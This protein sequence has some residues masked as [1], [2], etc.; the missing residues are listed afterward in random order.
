[1]RRMLPW[2][3]VPVLLAGGLWL[4]RPPT[5]GGDAA[6]PSFAVEGK[7]F[8]A[9]HCTSC[10]GGSAPEAGLSLEGLTLAPPTLRDATQLLDLRKRVVAR[11]MPPLG[12]PAPAPAELAAFLAA[13]DAALVAADAAL[14]PDPG[15]VTV[16]RLSR[17]EYGRTVKHLL[18][19]DYEPGASFPADDLSYGFDNIGASLSMSPL[20]LEKYADAAAEIAARAVWLE[21]PAHPPVRRLEAEGLEIEP[22]RAGAVRGEGAGLHGN[23][24]VSGTVRLPREG[25]YLLRARVFGQQAGPDP[26]RMAF[27]VDGR[28]V[29]TVDVP[30][31]SASIAVKEWR[32]ALGAGVR[33]VGVAFVN[34]Y[35]RP[36]EPDPAQRDRNLVVDWIEVV[37]PVDARP[38][39]AAH[40]RLFA[41]DP[42]A[43][44]RDPGK[45]SVKARAEPI[46][47][48][49]AS[50]AWRR[51]ATG[52]EVKRLVTL[53]EA[54]VERGVRLEEGVGLALQAVL[55][56]P[57]FLFRLE[58]GAATGAGGT[59]RDLDGHALATRLSY[60][61]WS[62]LPD[63]ALAVL[64]ARG[65]LA[66]LATL[67]AEVR[68]MLA[69][70]R[71]RALSENFAVQWLELRRL[72]TFVPDPERYPGFEALREPMRQEAEHL[73]EAV[74]RERRDVH[75][76]LDAR[77]TFVDAALAGHY[78]LPV[79]AGEGL[80][81]VDL[82]GGQRGGVLGLAGVLAVTSNPTRTSPV[83][84]GK[85]VL[86]NVL[87]APPRPPPPGAD[88]LDE[89]RVTASARSLRESMEVHRARA[90]CASC[91]VRMDA[92][93]F[94]LEGYDAVGRVRDGD[95]GQPVDTRGT[96]PDGREVDGLASLRGALREDRAFLRCLC[97]KLF[98]FAVGRAPE[99]RDALALFALVERLPRAKVTLEDLVLA[100]AG[101]EAFRK[102]SPGE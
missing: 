49:L 51:P 34:D 87:D 12:S 65:R 6:A 27:V 53:V 30:E 4:G 71:A 25:E 2:L 89:A 62:S 9:R 46:L 45:L 99:P 74:L 7:A 29:R 78:G 58:P 32:L 95:G 92:L 16:R 69:D 88:S 97:G 66:D 72:A 61:L 73:F 82:P 79:P 93:G 8:L 17:F 98:T 101:M 56:S 28:N 77:F 85:W 57:H 83:K 33:S 11:E 59:P 63:E 42:A 55:V 26:A 38:V 18:D 90:D 10:H 84:R 96:L 24:T 40:Q 23:G 81:R 102:R 13:T 14:A 3:L 36:Q 70:P 80:V 50:R 41:R 47:K 86:Q 43:K 37:G 19:L 94:A 76:L 44:A 91:H 22:G 15:R 31:T 67:Q 52:D 60:F 75:E 48:D 20:L 5:A 21:D 35:W 68:R 39:P 54:E 64:A 1:M 100:V